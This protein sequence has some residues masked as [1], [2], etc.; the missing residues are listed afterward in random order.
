MV[1]GRVWQCFS[2][3]TTWK[4]SRYSWKLAE[5]DINPIHSLTEYYCILAGL[6]L[7]L[8]LYLSRTFIH[9]WFTLPYANWHGPKLPRTIGVLY[10]SN[11]SRRDS[12]LSILNRFAYREDTALYSGTAVRLLLFPAFSL[13]Y[14]INLA[15]CHKIP[16]PRNLRTR[17]CNV[18]HTYTCY[19]Y[20]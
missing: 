13:H 1:I 18:L 2:L 6:F 19:D 7:F 16:L 3:M 15:S 4:F 12:F 11:P 14:I 17:N 10:S 5:R 9:F 20:A 8:C